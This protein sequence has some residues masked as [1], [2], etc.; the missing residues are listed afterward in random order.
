MC[1]AWNHSSG[2]DCGWGRGNNRRGGLGFLR[3]RSS[4]S[5][6]SSFRL[7]APSAASVA[8]GNQPTE[9]REAKTYETTCWWCGKTVFY[10]TNGH[11]DCVLFNTLGSPWAVHRCWTDYWDGRKALRQGSST[12]Q[13]NN[14]TQIWTRIEQYEQSGQT[15]AYRNLG[16]RPAKSA[17]HQRMA[18][19]AGAVSQSRFIPD[20]Q[21]VARLLGINIEQLKSSY[22]DLYIID[23]STN[24]IRLLSIDE[25]EERQEKAN[26]PTSAKKPARAVVV[27]RPRKSASKSKN[28]KNPKHKNRQEGSSSIQVWRAQPPESGSKSQKRKGKRR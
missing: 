13:T 12:K 17:F 26:Q 22:G 18:I 16:S 9:I 19:L 1:N 25:L 23:R 24:G 6:R 20:E 11:G 2:C 4:L 10:H 27:A 21:T 8:I 14:I 15:S 7:P 3:G 5:R 28:G